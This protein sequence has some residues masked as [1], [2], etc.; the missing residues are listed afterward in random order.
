MKSY[1]GSSHFPW[2]RI[3][4]TGFPSVSS[5]LFTHV[6]VLNLSLPEFKYAWLVFSSFCAIPI[7]WSIKL[8]AFPLK[9]YLKPR[10]VHLLL[11]EWHVHKIMMMCLLSASTLH[12]Y[13]R[14]SWSWWWSSFPHK[15]IWHFVKLKGKRQT[16]RKEEG[17]DMHGPSGY[18]HFGFAVH[19]ESQQKQKRTTG[20]FT[21]KVAPSTEHSWITTTNKK[22]SSDFR[23]CDCGESSDDELVKDESTMVWYSVIGTIN[24]VCIIVIA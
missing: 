17:Y 6:F 18:Y 12:M 7:A 22:L 10:T 4:S 21:H 20:K 14:W 23:R 19:R 13:L 2:L 1:N 3:G 11:L 24:F 16:S 5:L 8:S 15:L 9:F